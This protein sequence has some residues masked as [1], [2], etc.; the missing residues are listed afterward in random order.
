M[1]LPGRAWLQFE[2]DGDG[3]GSTIRQTAIFHPAGLLGTAYWYGLFPVHAWIFRGMLA[4]I[5]DA[6]QAPEGSRATSSGRYGPVSTMSEPPRR[7][8]RS[9]LVPLPLEDTFAFFADAY[10]LEALTPPWLR[11]RILTPRPIPM[12]EG[13]D[14]RVRAHHA[15]AARPLAHR[16]RRVETG[17]AVRGQAGEGPFRLWEHTHAFEERPDGTLIRDTVLY[18]MPYGPLGAIAHRVLVARDLER[19]FDYRRDAVERLLGGRRN[20][21]RAGRVRRLIR[22]HRP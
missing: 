10:N 6:A 19:I 17:T 22:R 14:D 2:V 9:Q 21:P 5:A 7:I 13:N 12:R 1:R 20:T 18:R 16:D 8:E 15:P 4:R 3:A 11:F